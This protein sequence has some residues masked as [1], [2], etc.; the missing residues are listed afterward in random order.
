M[1]YRLTWFHVTTFFN[2]NIHNEAFL[3]TSWKPAI[4]QLMSNHPIILMI[5]GEYD[6]KLVGP[7]IEFVEGLFGF[8][9]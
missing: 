7:M 5:L 9:F 8:K 3:L 6:L 4:I 1:N 2:N